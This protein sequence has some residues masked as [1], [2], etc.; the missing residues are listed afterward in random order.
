MKNNKTTRQEN[1]EKIIQDLDDAFGV[2]KTP[3]Q[4]NEYLLKRIHALRAQAEACLQRKE[5]LLERL[6]KNLTK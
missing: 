5:T 1:L 6:F 4:E 2:K 3:E